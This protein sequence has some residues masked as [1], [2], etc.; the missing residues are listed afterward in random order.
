[1]DEELAAILATM[2]EVAAAGASELSCALEAEEW[3]S[4][5]IGSWRGGLTRDPDIDR[6]F[7]AGLARK[8]EELG[9]PA[10]LTALRALGS[11]G[12]ESYAPLAERAARRLARAGMR[13]PAWVKALGHAGPA[14]AML[15]CSDDGFD[16]GVS[17]LVEFAAPGEDPH[18]LGI[19]IDHNLGGLV[20][21]V[22]IAGRIAIVSEQFVA[23]AAKDKA[24]SPTEIDLADARA[25]VECAL[26]MLDHT[27][28][29]PVSEDVFPLRTF[30]RARM[31]TLPAGGN[32][33]PQDL[34][35]PA[36]ERERLLADFLD[37]PDGKGWGGDEDAQDVV[38]LAISFG[39]DY[40]HGGPLRW[41]PVVVEIFMTDWLA[42]KVVREREFFERVPDVLRDWVRFAGH[43]RGVP[44]ASL[45][46]AVAA[47]KRFRKEM[48]ELTQD[49][50]C[51]GPA[52]IFA[53]AAGQAG[54]DL[55]DPDAMNTFIET[56]N[57]TNAPL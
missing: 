24:V 48:L 5:M 4:A 3:A 39:C 22:F 28:A 25:R 57:G 10:A 46:H 55:T 23:Q 42:R 44:A 34:E 30:M 40:N 18:T 31:R 38:E 35:V 14:Q 27:L 33:A 56:Y 37:S 45:R 21:D 43:R 9:G 26:E 47:V 54:V 17:V 19:Y 32:A 41:S 49:A 16:D 12:E 11:V 13:E 2:A 7:G 50:D 6:L 52:K 15:M 36:G 20:K 1:M 29:P 53:M 51:W 8:L